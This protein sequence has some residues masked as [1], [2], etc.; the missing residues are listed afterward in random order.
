M[1]LNDILSFS[2]GTITVQTIVFAVLIALVGVGIA[3]LLL[4]AVKK[5][6]SKSSFDHSLQNVLLIIVRIVLYVIVSLVVADYLGLPVTSLLAVVSVAGLAVS[7]AI[8]DSLANVFG[9]MLLLAAKTF[10]SGDYVQLNGLEGTVIDVNLMNTNLR[11]ADGKAVRI[12]NKDVQAAPIVNYSSQPLRRVEV[13]VTASYDDATANVKAALCDAID[14][15]PLLLSDPAPVVALAAYQASSIEYVV[16][17][18]TVSADYWTAFYALNEA[19]RDCFDKHN[20]HMTYDHV[21]VHMV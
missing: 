6:L 1:N 7:L 17:A 21:N 8:Q 18:W 14:C 13:R 12:P 2:I 19:I 15:V 9:G 11:T 20:I 10:K 5:L 3:K 4:R 16:Q